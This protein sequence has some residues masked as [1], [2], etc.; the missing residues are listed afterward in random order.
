MQANLAFREATGQTAVTHSNPTEAELTKALL[1]TTFHHFG[2]GAYGSGYNVT[3]AKGGVAR[4]KT[5]E[6]LDDAPYF[7]WKNSATSWK[8]VKHEN[9]P[10]VGFYLEIGGVQFRLDN[11]TQGDLNWIPLNAEK[12]SPDYYRQ[13][14]STSDSFCDA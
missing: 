7:R 4:E 5:M 11:E 10:I 12:D 1:G 13:T 6:L 3:L 14:L 2:Q 9:A 8:L